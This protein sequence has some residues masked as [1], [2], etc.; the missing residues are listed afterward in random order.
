MTVC[1]LHKVVKQINFVLLLSY[2]ID[3]RS[4]DRPNNN[5]YK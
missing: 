5:L 2:I 3:D 4:N 1:N